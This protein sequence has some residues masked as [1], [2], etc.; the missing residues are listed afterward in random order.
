MSLS[1]VDFR[2][3][4]SLPQKERKSVFDTEAGKSILSRMTPAQI[5][6]LFPDYYKQSLTFT[7]KG[8]FETLP[9][10]LPKEFNYDTKQ[11]G[12]DQGRVSTSTGGGVNNKPSATIIHPETDPVWKPGGKAGQTAV[13]SSPSSNTDISSA[14]IAARRAKFAEEIAKN[15]KLRDEL[16]G[17][18]VTEDAQNPVPVLESLFNRMD[19]THGTLEGGLHSG[20]Y[21]P[22]NHGKLPGAI[23]QVQNNPKLKAK[24]DSA[25]DTVIAGSNVIH[26]ATDQG[27]PSDPNGR[28]PSGRI[29]INGEVFND[30]GI[31]GSKEYR[32]NFEKEYQDEQLKIAEDN[33]KVAAAKAQANNK[34]TVAEVGAPKSESDANAL[35]AAASTGSI[36]PESTGV[37]EALKVKGLTDKS[38]RTQIVNYIKPDSEKSDPD[39]WRDDFVNQAVSA[40][41]TANTT[42]QND[43]ST[44]PTAKETE[45]V[46]AATAKENQP[47]M[48]A[49]N[50]PLKEK[51]TP[52]QI[53]FKETV[54]ELK[55]NPPKD[56]PEPQAPIPLDRII[57]SLAIRGA[58]DPDNPDDFGDA[59]PIEPKNDAGQIIALRQGTDMRGDGEGIPLEG[60]IKIQSKRATHV[61]EDSKME[62]VNLVAR[63]KNVAESVD[64]Q[65]YQRLV[66][67]EKKEVE[68][69]PVPPAEVMQK[70]I[71]TASNKGSVPTVISVS[72]PIS[73]N[74]MKRYFSQNRQQKPFSETPIGTNNHYDETVV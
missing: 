64:Q 8:Y 2:E 65:P 27:L 21:G 36:N 5:A 53:K 44:A 34:T 57:P 56:P 24:M 6:E 22:I 71:M 46:A 43:H 29:M 66:E 10:A 1:S 47:I 13:P 41:E 69:P 67:T 28:N 11:Q 42:V 7:Q 19:F 73:P 33:R 37:D 72:H 50:E 35:I 31:K 15:P 4:Q 17:M 51:A 61:I 74:S 38:D 18:A 48:V 63:P 3:I 39:K 20:F 16:M 14:T 68:E 32:E 55:R 25:I 45:P 54:E 30:I 58:F 49:E 60:Q 23:A 12:D 62:D 40:N 59:K 52:G 9:E 70:P 26:G